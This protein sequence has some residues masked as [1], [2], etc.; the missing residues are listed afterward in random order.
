M[1]HRY[2]VSKTSYFSKSAQVPDFVIELFGNRYAFGVLVGNRFRTLGLFE[3]LSMLS[4]VN[5]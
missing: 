1:A 5:V 4:R 2:R 3:T